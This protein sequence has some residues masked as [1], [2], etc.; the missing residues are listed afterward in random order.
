MTWQLNFDKS[1]P[2]GMSFEGMIKSENYRGLSLSV[3]V[4]ERSLVKVLPQKQLK[5]QDWKEHAEKL[6][7]STIKSSGKDP[8]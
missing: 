4:E 7:C 8:G 6:R 2:G 1:H 3:R 5:A